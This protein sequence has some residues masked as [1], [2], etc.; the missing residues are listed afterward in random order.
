MTNEPTKFLVSRVRRWSEEND[1]PCDGAVWEAFTS[2]DERIFDDP[3]K[4]PSYQRCGSTDEWYAHGENHRVE[5]GHIKR[6]FESHAWFIEIEILGELMEFIKE[7]GYDAII[8]KAAQNDSLYS[9]QIYDG[10]VE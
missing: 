3:S 8:G 6:D 9:L 1:K 10:Y 7:Q 5:N 4:I 2:I